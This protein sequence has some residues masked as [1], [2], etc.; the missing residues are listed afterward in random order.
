M[1][2]AALPVKR[3]TDWLTARGA[4]VLNPTNPYEM[5]RFTTERGLGIVYTNS[6]GRV[7]H[8]GEAAKAYN[9]FKANAAWDAG[10]AAPRRKTQTDRLVAQ[11]RERD[12]SGCFF[13][14]LPVTDDASIEHLV[15]RGHGGPSH[16]SNYALAHRMCNARA[17]HLPLMEKIRM[18]EKAS[19]REVAA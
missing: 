3:F 15:P 18:R 2:I 19:I 7:T 11:L 17:G 12:G 1:G 4:Q 6:R 13:C 14:R 5:V 9:A 10:I 8:V 16:L